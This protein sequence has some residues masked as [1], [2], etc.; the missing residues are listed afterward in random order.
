MAQVAPAS[1]LDARADR[2]LSYLRREW[3]GVQE[4]VEQWDSWDEH[5]RLVFELN[6]AVPED[7]LAQLRSWYEADLLSADRRRHY[8]ELMALVDRMRPVLDR[9]L[10]H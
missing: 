2:Y 9:M 8:E 3:R 4:L 7:R 5:S 10:D 6:W 1:S